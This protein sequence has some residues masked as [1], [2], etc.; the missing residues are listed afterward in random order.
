MFDYD[1][2]DYTDAYY[3]PAPD[4]PEGDFDDDGTCNACDGTGEGHNDYTSCGSCGGSGH[5]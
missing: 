1:D 5:S 3:D 2:Y 4:E